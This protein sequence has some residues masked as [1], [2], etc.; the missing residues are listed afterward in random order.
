MIP[1]VVKLCE[2]PNRDG[3]LLMINYWLKYATRFV[4]STIALVLRIPVARGLSNLF[5]TTVNVIQTTSMLPNG[6]SF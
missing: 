1:V 6:K 4:S 5:C 3:G 2:S